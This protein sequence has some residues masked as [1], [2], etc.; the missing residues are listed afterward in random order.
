MSILIEIYQYSCNKTTHPRNYLGLD[1]T[2]HFTTVYAPAEHR[3]NAGCIFLSKVNL[4]SPQIYNTTHKNKLEST[5][6]KSFLPHFGLA[7]WRRII[8][9]ISI[10]SPYISLENTKQ[11]TEVFKIIFL[12]VWSYGCTTYHSPGVSRKIWSTRLMLRPCPEHCGFC[13]SSRC[14]LDHKDT[15]RW[16]YRPLQVFRNP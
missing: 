9:A 6:L 12:F 10:P 3:Q 16:S 5:Q 14:K 8:C 4:Y 15:V 11:L 7:T 2:G 13:I 1:Y